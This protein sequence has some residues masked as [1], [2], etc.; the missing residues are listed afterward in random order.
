MVHYRSYLDKHWLELF[1]ST[2]TNHGIIIVV[3]WQI[4]IK[5]QNN[6]KLQLFDSHLQYVDRVDK[7]YGKKNGTSFAKK[8]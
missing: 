4:K 5:D 6:H 8:C 3:I 2:K 1:D 7:E